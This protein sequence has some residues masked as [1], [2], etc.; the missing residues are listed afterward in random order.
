MLDIKLSLINMKEEVTMLYVMLT[1][2]AR[3]QLMLYAEREIW[4]SSSDFLPL[5]AHLHPN[6]GLSYIIGPERGQFQPKSY[7]LF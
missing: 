1:S 5:T 7:P 3:W 2:S 4:E 6:N